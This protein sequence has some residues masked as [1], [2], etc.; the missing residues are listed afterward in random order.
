MS[1]HIHYRMIS[2]NLFGTN[3]VL[4]LVTVESLL[5]SDSDMSKCCANTACMFPKHVSIGHSGI[6]LRLTN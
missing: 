6:Q 2:S 1:A 3:N 4:Y 5:N